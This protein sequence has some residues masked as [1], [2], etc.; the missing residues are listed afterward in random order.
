MP[1]SSADIEAGKSD[2]PPPLSPVS[3]EDASVPISTPVRGVTVAEP[4]PVPP[5][6]PQP[7]Q[8]LPSTTSPILTQALPSR[9]LGLHP[10]SASLRPGSSTL[11]VN[12][13]QQ[14]VASPNAGPIQ[15]PLP[16][17]ISATV[18]IPPPPPPPSSKR[19]A[20][21]QADAEY[22][23]MFKGA[24]P[25]QYAMLAH[26]MAY[27]AS[28]ICV[29]CGFFSLLWLDRATHYGCRVEGGWISPY[30]IHKS[31]LSKYPD[32]KA[33]CQN[34]WDDDV[35]PERYQPK[36]CCDPDDEPGVD[37][38]MY[39]GA[40]ALIFG[41]VLPMFENT[42][43]G[44][45]LWFPVDTTWYIHKVSPMAI[46]CLG[47]GSFLCSHYVTATAGL[48]LILSSYPRYMA[49]RYEEG[50]DGGRGLRAAIR[51]REI[52]KAR[53]GVVAMSGGAS[54]WMAYISLMSH[55]MFMRFTQLFTMTHWVYVYR[56]LVDHDKLAT[57]V[58][59][60]LFMSGNLVLFGYTVNHWYNIID[61]VD[62]DLKKGRLD[63]RCSS[64]ECDI[65][66]QYI[67]SGPPSN[68]AP[69]A[70]GAGACLNLNCSLILLPVVKLLLRKLSD[71]G[72]AVSKIQRSST[73]F[74][75]LCAGPIARYVP[76]QH[77]IAFHKLVA[78]AVF[79]F[80]LAHIIFHLSNLTIAADTT[81]RLFTT[82]G[83]EYT[84]FLTGI[85]IT[86]AMFFIY[87]G[88]PADV[89]S[90]KYELFF[91]SH[92]MFIVFFLVLMLHGPVFIYWSI[93]PIVLYLVEK[94]IAHFRSSTPFKL[95]KVEWI[96]P[97]MA[98]HFLPLVK[99]DFQFKEGQYL[100]LKC[101][102][103]SESEYHPFTI[104]S[105]PGDM[106]NGPLICTETG[107][108]V[109]AV[110]RPS[111]WP[112]ALRWRK[113]CPMSKDWRT[114]RPED[115]LDRGDVSYADFVSCH[116]KVHGWNDR[117]A[118]T[119]TRKVKDFLEKVAPINRV[120]GTKF[121]MY[122]YQRDLRDE[123]SN[124][125]VDGPSGKPLILVDGPHS[126]PAQSY[127]DYNTVMLVGAGIG[128]TPCTSILSSLLKYRWRRGFP[129]ELLHFHWVI[130]HNEIN[131]YQWVVHLLTELLYDLKKGKRS[132]A[133]AAR[134]YCEVNIYVTGYNSNKADP[135][136]TTW[137]A[138]KVPS[139]RLLRAPR[140]YSANDV[141]PTFQAEELF[142]LLLKPTVSS[143]DQVECMK[144]PKTAPNRLQNLWVWNG[145]PDWDQVFRKMK[146]QRQDKDIG[147]CFC[148]APVIGRD[149]QRM[150][151]KYSNSKEQCL[152]TLHKENF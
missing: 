61:E 71:I 20:E 25:L 133:I 70:K 83:W 109:V 5:R 24:E 10:T 106:D 51:A 39:T 4:Q 7:H 152:F 123:L 65:A 108:E 84:A 134:Y 94:V 37:G 99:R 56:Q 93:V 105:A 136:K 28:I 150:C 18:A 29:V 40:I 95:I 113:Y 104:S 81:F 149:L 30:Y 112:E 66:R 137:D 50:G 68:W 64:R 9:N 2:K 125:R 130:R 22:K 116:I 21:D 103:V 33:M 85:I 129:P 148:G 107:E 62:H 75:F 14:A 47:I 27:G 8:P 36:S 146:E 121:P 48:A 3:A 41:L 74:G 32:S 42:S 1:L 34:S 98:M 52:A 72:I 142:R 80:S 127:S 143:K 57:N 89:K 86:L 128:L 77:N 124:G 11:G 122:F 132:T 43:L 38:E 17:A 78:V 120:T 87:S 44:W 13:L 111:N 145:R 144:S 12:Y 101:P 131:A 35:I 23:A 53:K 82:W 76:L 102:E 141:P 54:D 49:R 67:E 55:R 117:D 138:G 45:G 58:W 96:P 16:A 69:W 114:L 26:Y 15:N 140:V 91:N 97:V 63:T 59:L 79:V 118:L 46:F 100:Q 90:A 147:V 139:E 126:A 115:L 6:H 151:Q 110:P 92:H 119:W 73:W 88:A 31:A 19:R 135:D 60:L